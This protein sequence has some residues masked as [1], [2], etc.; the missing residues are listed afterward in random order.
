[1]HW[2][3]GALRGFS[4]W[5][6]FWMQSIV[7][8]IT[9]AQNAQGHGGQP[10]D[11]APTVGGGEGGGLVVLEREET[12]S[13]ASVSYPVWPIDWSYQGLTYPRSMTHCPESLEH[14]G[15]TSQDDSVAGRWS[16]P[17]NIYHSCLVGR[18]RPCCIWTIILQQPD[19]YII[20]RK[21]NKIHG[22][23]LPSAMV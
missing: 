1:M 16:R 14:T 10:K 8:T 17:Y 11:L 3:A 19:D 15:F 13:L 12:L 21:I 9:L 20:L 2:P 7:T 22:S 23:D 18:Q 5:A 4:H 6:P